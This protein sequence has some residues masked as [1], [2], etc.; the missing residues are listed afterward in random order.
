MN[1]LYPLS[2]KELCNRDKV[3]IRGNKNGNV[4]SVCPCQAD[5]VRDDAGIDTLFF[6][7]SHVAAATR[8]VRHFCLTMRALR[9]AHLL[10]SLDKHHMRSRHPVK[11]VG[12][13]IFQLRIL[14][15]GWV[16]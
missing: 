3:A 15:F 11:R 9:I 7:A 6:G 5:H 1:D 12:E 4:V 2:L 14:R 16:E 8:A 13:P 10:L